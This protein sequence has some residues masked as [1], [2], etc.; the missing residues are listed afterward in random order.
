MSMT[1]T[2]AIDEFAAALARIA[3][4]VR[5]DQLTATTPC[6]GFTTAELLD[7]L[8][9]ALGVLERAARKE[10]QDAPGSAPA[11]A[12]RAAVAEAALSVAAAWREPSAQEGTTELRSRT[13]PAAFVA[14]LTLQELALHSW[15]VARATGQPLI[16]GDDAGRAVLDAVHQVAERARTSGAYGSP[17]A[18]PADASSFAQALADSG[19]DPRWGA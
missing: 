10:P 5:D 8:T 6:E 7:H 12:G 2:A 11:A 4:G 13:M 15:D 16:V 1:I 18:P 19:R 14:V 9:G 17:V 3:S